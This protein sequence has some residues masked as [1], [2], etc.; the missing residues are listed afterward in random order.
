MEIRQFRFH[1]GL[2][3]EVR[4][5]HT[6]DNHLCL[7]DERDGARKIALAKNRAE[8]FGASADVLCER[9]RASVA[10]AKENRLLYL[11]TGDILDFVSLANLEF[12]R[13]TLEGC[14]YLMAAGNHEYSLYVGEAWEDEAYKQQSFALVQSYFKP[15]LVFDAR[16]VGGVN[17]VTLDNVYYNFTAYQLMRMKEEAKKGFP[18]IL[19]VHTPFY[20]PKLY[21]FMMETD[22][23]CAYLT[24]HRKKKSPATMRTATVSRRRTRQR[25]PLWISPPTSRLSA[26]SSQGT[27]I[28]RL[29][30]HCHG[31]AKSPCWWAVPAAAAA[32][33]KSSLTDGGCAG[34]RLIPYGSSVHAARFQ[35]NT[36]QTN[37]P[38][39]QFSAGRGYLSRKG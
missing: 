5:L 39:P 33:P 8:A 26:A 34:I 23:S 30:I 13:Q 10:Y 29:R 2:P 25:S 38:C 24:A 12:A 22:G 37:T 18:I 3:R 31:T 35:A 28:T 7:A 36:V 15:N 19:C 17:F 9:F 14:D 16:I 11:S 27:V 20:A 21:D 6:T 32:P 4:L 1:V